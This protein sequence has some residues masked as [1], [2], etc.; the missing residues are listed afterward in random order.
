MK[1]A[2]VRIRSLR[3]R[4]LSTVVR[5]E[6]D[7][8]GTPWSWR[9]FAFEV[10]RPSSTCLAAVDASGLA[11]YLVCSPQDHLRHVRNLAVHRARRGRGIGSTL[12]SALLEQAQS[13]EHEYVLEVRESAGGAIAMYQRFG[14]RPA[15]RRPAFYRD[16]RED[17]LILWLSRPLR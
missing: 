14:F 11:G 2:A 7:A 1:G 8:F 5:I 9:E 3:Y 16:D 15:G 17:A 6:R 10:S 12:L 13:P 4:D